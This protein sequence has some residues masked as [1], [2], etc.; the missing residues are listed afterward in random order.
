MGKKL[1]L[2]TT[3]SAARTMKWEDSSSRNGPTK[4]QLL[5]ALGLA[6][7]DKPIGVAILNARY[8]KDK[9]SIKLI[10]NYLFSL[11]SHLRPEY[12]TETQKR[13]AIY[14]LIA[15]AMSVPIDVTMKRVVSAWK[16]Y[17]MKG[18]R[19]KKQIEAL[20]KA[21][22]SLKRAINTKTSDSEIYQLKQQVNGLQ[23]RING[24]LRE[25]DEY[26]QKK[27]AESLKCPRCRST[28]IIQKTQRVCTTCNGVG[29]FRVKDTD[30]RKSLMD[31]CPEEAQQ[32]KLHWPESLL[33]MKRAQELL[34]RHVLDA[35]TIIERRLGAEYE[36][37]D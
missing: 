2:L 26:A 35:T 27:A 28:G 6:Q 36:R 24:H 10:Q 3:L 30:W 31:A 21:V 37:E 32:F 14:L 17:S 29:E 8:A 25:L 33:E 20:T 19:T 15:D 22:N 23:E 12:F 13:N 11:D 18:D 4:E 16:R 7:R 5:G 1:E 34:Q 9:P